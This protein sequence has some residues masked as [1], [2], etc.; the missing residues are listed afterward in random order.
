[1]NNQTNNIPSNNSP[2]VGD[3]KPTN[4]INYQQN[5][6]PAPISLAGPQQQIPYT[7]PP[8]SLN[9]NYNNYQRQVP[10]YQGQQAYMQPVQP[11]QLSYAQ[12]PQTIREPNQVAVLVNPVNVG[13]I[14]D[15][16]IHSFRTI[17]PH[18]NK[19]VYTLTEY[20]N[21]SMVWLICILLFFFT[22]FFCCC[23]FCINGIKDVVH[24]CPACSK[25]I[26]IHRFN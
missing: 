12:I 13:F 22:A 3:E 19:Y 25:V 5:I 4:N 1:M 20:Q 15:P 24:R 10:I 21:N 26:G 7:Q 17:C 2:F 23:A 8:N 14:G 9:L 18:C 11:G 16:P 6:N